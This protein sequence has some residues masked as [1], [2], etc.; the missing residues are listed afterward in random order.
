M[1]KSRFLWLGIIISII[2]L[3]TL[4]AIFVP[5]ST[6]PFEV[7]VNFVRAAGAGDEATARQYLHPDLWAYADANCRE[8]RIVNCVDDYTPSEWGD[9]LSAVFR[10]AEP[11]GPDV[12]DVSVIA[13]YAQDQGFS[14]VC[15]YNR[16]EKIQGQWQIVAWSG[17]ISCDEPNA[18]LS[19]LKQS[20]APNRAP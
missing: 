8:G 16:V 14:G 9:L 20:D 3:I 7:A 6:P 19:A 15:I 1:F 12:W 10:R 18:G 5:S 13:T 2:L 4:T 11:D 17:F